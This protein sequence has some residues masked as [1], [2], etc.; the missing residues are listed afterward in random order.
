MS[1]AEELIKL[2][3]R[4]TDA[5]GHGVIDQNLRDFYEGTLIQIMNEA[6]RQRQDCVA[7]ADQLRRQVSVLEGQAQAFSQQSSIVYSVLNGFI[8][9]AEKAAYAEAQAR[10]DAA[11]NAVE[12]TEEEKENLRQIAEKQEGAKTRKRR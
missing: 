8:I 4:V 7:Q 11:R 9:Q 5:V 10:E 3:K 1:Y 2:R 12:Q 6:E